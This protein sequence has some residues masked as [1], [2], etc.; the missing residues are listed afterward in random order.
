MTEALGPGLPRKEKGHEEARTCREK[1][2]GKGCFRGLG[3]RSGRL[4]RGM[5]VPE[6]ASVIGLHELIGF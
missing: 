3:I 2:S 1:E 4:R 5:G 6:E